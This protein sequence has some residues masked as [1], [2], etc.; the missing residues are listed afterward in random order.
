MHKGQMECAPPLIFDPRRRLTAQARAV[1]RGAE[2]SFLLDQMADE[3]AERLALVSRS[4]DDILILGPVSALSEKI[5]AG[6]GK[7][8]TANATIDEAALPYDPASF[9]LIISAGTLDSV[10]DLP[11]ALVQIKTALRPDGLFL[12]VLYG[13]GSLARLKAAM[14]AADGDN[15]RPHFHPQID[16]RNISELMGRAGFALPVADLD[17]LTVRY[18]DWRRLVTDLREAGAGNALASPRP[19]M[20]TM[21]QRLD[22]AWREMAEPDGKV[23]ENF[24]FLHISGWAPSPHQPQP[25]R[26]GSGQLSLA[27]VLKK[28]D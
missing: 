17:R 11:G 20:R 26:R 3:L 13:Q 16:L 15:A 21:L 23:G 7:V 25:A 8:V 28:P 19:F 24:S 14:L 9:D 5:L 2:R 27:D 10:N 1:A 6:Q 22:K 12:G 4:F 18:G